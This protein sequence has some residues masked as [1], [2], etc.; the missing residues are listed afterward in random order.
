MS[1]QP[2]V[3][4]TITTTTVKLLAVDT[5]TKTTDEVQVTL[6]RTYKNDDALLKMANKRRDN[7]HVKFV[8]VLDAPVVQKKRWGM[9]E[10]EFI[11]AGR[12]FPP[13]KAGDDA[14]DG[15]YADTDSVTPTEQ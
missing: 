4:R 13:Y 9:T 2:V 10:E 6:P 7:E 3:T 12:E 14:D 11:D 15:D 8:A 5:A 1:R